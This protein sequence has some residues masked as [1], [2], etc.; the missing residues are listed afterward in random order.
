VSA[1]A[2]SPDGA[3]AATCYARGDVAV[4]VWDVAGLTSQVSPP[5]LGKGYIIKGALDTRK[6][7]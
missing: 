7:R 3:W 1:V 6:I 4:G 5:V 2:L